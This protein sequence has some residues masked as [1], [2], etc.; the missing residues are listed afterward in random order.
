RTPH[1]VTMRE[2][3]IWCCIWVVLSLIFCALF[4]AYVYHKFP[5]NPDV[6]EQLALEYL[7]GYVAEK[8]LSVDNIFVCIVVF[9]FLHIPQALQHKVLFYG[10]IGAF[11]FRG[12]FIALGSYLMAIEAVV[13]GFGV[14]LIFTGV[15]IIF[16]PEKPVLP[17]KNPV[18]RFAKKIMPVW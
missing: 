3:T 1:K 17:E 5:H 13:I 15:K 2:A 8:S 18:I 14:F 4:Y 16:S 10:I 12:I 9:N 11:I 6:A 7:A